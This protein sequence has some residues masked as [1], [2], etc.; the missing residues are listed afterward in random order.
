MKLLSLRCVTFLV[1]ASSALSLLAFSGPARA[2]VRLVYPTARYPIPAFEDSSNQKDGPCGAPNDSRTRDASR[3]TTLRAGQTISV[4]FRE[5]INH[6]GHFR[7]AFDADG[8]DDFRDPAGFTD[9]QRNPTLPI[10]LDGITDKAGGEY[11]VSVTLPNIACERC[12][13]QLIQVMTDK[14]PTYGDN[15]L[16][17]QCADIV[18]TQA[19]GTGDGGP[20]GTGGAGSGGTGAAGTGSG[21]TG[22]ST[23]GTGSGGTGASTGGTGSGGTGVSTG[24]VGGTG[25]GGTSPSGAGGGAGTAGSAARGGSS[26]K[27]ESGSEPASESDGCQVPAAAQRSPGVAAALLLGLLLAARWRRPS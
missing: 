12:T 15:D 26:G 17:Y 4:Q 23:G 6:P 8:Q 1:G 2:H 13:L 21:G 9:I 20:G 11:T 14:G 19:P 18:L 22:V 5:T 10:L 3:V 27:G 24:G 25:T 7:I 16:Y